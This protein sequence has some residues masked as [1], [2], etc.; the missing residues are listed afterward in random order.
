MRSEPLPY[1]NRV[2]P[3]GQIIAT[4]ARG[5]LMGNRGCLHDTS[6]HPLRQYQGRRWIICVLDFKER[7]RTPMPPGHYTSLFFLDEATALAAGHRPCAECQRAR[8]TTFRAQWAAANPD[9][10]RSA[11]PTV[12][13]IDA[14]LHRERISDHRYQREKVKLTY[15]EHL[16]TLPNGVFVVLEPKGA[17]YLV[18]GNQLFP[19]SFAGYDR[20]CARP[21][22]I[23]QVLT[24]RSTVRAMAHGYAPG[25]HPSARILT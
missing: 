5:T 6:D 23:V 12:D 24:P 10:A 19:W 25:I 14:V 1:Q 15:T 8:F 3:F 4:P 18:H 16:E 17:P 9:L 11:A 20:P 22:T 7:T 2:N 21:V 13:V